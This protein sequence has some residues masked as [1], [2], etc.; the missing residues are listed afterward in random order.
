MIN[1]AFLLKSYSS[2]I[3][4][5]STYTSEEIKMK[6]IYIDHTVTLVDGVNNYIIPSEDIERLLMRPGTRVL[7]FKDGDEI[8]SVPLKKAVGEIE[9]YDMLVTHFIKNN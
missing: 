5:I 2:F 6:F 7:R 9:G 1:H 4:I 8:Q 3:I